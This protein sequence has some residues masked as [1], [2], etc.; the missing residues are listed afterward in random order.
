MPFSNIIKHYFLSIFG[1]DVG[2]LVVRKR[3]TPV[4]DPKGGVLGHFRYVLYES[5]YG[6]RKYVAINSTLGRK[7]VATFKDDEFYT[8]VIL[9]WKEG[10]RTPGVQTYEQ[11]EQQQTIDI[12]AGK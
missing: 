10:I 6:V 7:I 12:L 5:K 3:A 8:N 1:A 4:V 9:P 11:A 2:W